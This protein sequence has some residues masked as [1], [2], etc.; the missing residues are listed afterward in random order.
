MKTYFVSYCYTTKDGNYGF[1][2]TE[3][4]FEHSVS[5]F[6]DLIEA[7]EEISKKF[8]YENTIILNYKRI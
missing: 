5:C 3:V 7:Q 2:S 4:G 1:G 6:D 8:G